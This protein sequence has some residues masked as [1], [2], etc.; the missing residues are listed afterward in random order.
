MSV[1]IPG[2]KGDI[3]V[4]FPIQPTDPKLILPFGKLVSQTRGARLWIGQS[5]NIETH[6]LLAYLVGAGIEVPLGTSVALAPPL[7]QPFD[8]AVSARSIA[9][10]SGHS[11]VAGIGA[12]TPSFVA[13]VRGTPFASPRTAISEYV[14]IM[15]GL[16]QGQ[17]LDSQGE[18]FG[19]T[20]RLVPFEH[21]EVTIGLGVLRARMAVT[22]GAIADQA[23]SWLTP[24]KYVAEV[25]HPA[26]L[27]GALSADR[28]V[29]HFTAVVQVA[30]E[31]S[32][33]N[34]VELAL[35]SAH[36]HLEASHYVQMLRRAG[37]PIG[38]GTLRDDA[39]ALVTHG[40]FLTGSPQEIVAGIQRY[41]EAGVDE[42]V[43]NVGGVL[44]TEG[45][46]AAMNDLV[47]ILQEAGRL[48]NPATPVRPSH[49]VP[50]APVTG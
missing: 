32:G 33:R 40:A 7:R 6:H 49:S 4:I 28:S 50:S 46:V 26:L 11:F 45:V 13:A 41:H 16:L 42:V 10:L 17:F 47:A 31:K 2:S 48:G 8:A 20:G 18:Y 1:R 30:T 12:A 19:H 29:P 34:P 36:R 5:L 25:L 23:I 21:P 14:A 39:A 9:A 24:P 43:L 27:E 38:E 44:A 15:R 22:A 3:S 37:L 35:H